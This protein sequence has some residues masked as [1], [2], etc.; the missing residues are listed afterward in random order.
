MEQP[1]LR[2][3]APAALKTSTKPSASACSATLADPGTTIKRTE[4]A[5][6]LPFKIAAAALKSSM[7]PFVHEP[8]NTVS[9]FIS[10]IFVPGFRSMYCN[11][12]SAALF[13]TGSV[14]LSGSGTLEVIGTP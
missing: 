2:Q 8:K 10:L 9:T 13:S 14:K 5:I 12:L 11:A 3:S 6:F 7:R 4:S 1:A